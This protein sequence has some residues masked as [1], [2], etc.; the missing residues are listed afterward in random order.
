MLAKYLKNIRAERVLSE[1]GRN[2][3]M[4]ALGNSWHFNEGGIHKEFM[5]PTYEGANNF[6]V[7]YN[8]YCSKIN[9]K[10]IWKNVY[11]T[12]KIEL[13]DTEFENVT[14]QDIEIAKYLDTVYDV[15]LNF[16]NLLLEDKVAVSG[17]LL[18]KAK[19]E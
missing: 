4:E 5:F 11:N 16:D 2:N 8:N 7:R 3:A 1:T 9:K 14:T 6:M 13:K 18:P 19:R 17:V 15:T 12:V 10:P